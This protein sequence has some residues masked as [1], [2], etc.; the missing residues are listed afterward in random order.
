LKAAL[1]DAPREKM[2]WIRA[3]VGKQIRLI[4]VA[5]VLFFQSDAKYTRVVTSAFEA[6]VRIPLKDLLSG[7][8]PAMF[9]QIHRGTMV[10]VN[11]I[12]AAERIDA[13]RLQVLLRGH[14]EKLPVSRSF[15][16][17]FRD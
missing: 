11:A 7:L 3:S 5:D 14:P 12:A 4:N 10:N 6:L 13:E 2:T 17:L 9:W 1:P 15:T 8:D 16:H